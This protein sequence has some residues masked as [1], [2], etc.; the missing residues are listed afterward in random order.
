MF[1]I[2]VMQTEIYWLLYRLVPQIW[3]RNSFLEKCLVSCDLLDFFKF[4]PS[5]IPSLKAALLYEQLT[6]IIITMLNWQF[7]PY[8]CNLK[9]LCGSRIPE[10]SFWVYNQQETWCFLWQGFLRDDSP[11]TIL[12][13]RRGSGK[14]EMGFYFHESFLPSSLQVCSK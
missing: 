4:S 2:F 3:K 13:G 8:V 12:W 14:G 9:F 1:L 7:W 11:W 10:S 6:D 5:S